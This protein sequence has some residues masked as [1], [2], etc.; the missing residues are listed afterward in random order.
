MKLQTVTIDRDGVP[1]VVNKTD[2]KQGDVIWGQSKNEPESGS[3]DEK[4]ELI[5]VLSE[6]GIT[7]DRRSSLETLKEL[8]SEL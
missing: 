6:H 5:A 3:L 2:V 1:V 7:K 4:D 8:V